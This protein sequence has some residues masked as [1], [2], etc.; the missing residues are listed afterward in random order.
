MQS[1][2]VV[3]ASC[4]ALL[5][6]CGAASGGR[7]PRDASI[8]HF[9]SFGPGVTGLTSRVKEERLTACLSGA[10]GDDEDA[11]QW[12]DNIRS[13]M[14]KWINPLR[15]LTAARL[16][17]QI[18][19][20]RD[21]RGCDVDVDV[22]PNTHSN[23]RIGQQPLIRMGS[24]GYM[25]SYNVLLHEFGHAFALNDTYQDGTT[26]GNCIAGQPQAVMCN[27]GFGD[28]Q[29]DDVR[30]VQ[31]VFRQAFPNDRPPEP[32]QPSYRLFAALGPGD[33]T[34]RAE[35]HLGLSG[36]AEIDGGAMAWCV[37]PAVDCRIDGAVWNEAR[38]EGRRGDAVLFR[39]GSEL[40]LAASP[41]ITIRYKTGRGET[42]RELEIVRGS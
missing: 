39:S 21:S 38:R 25:A 14:L 3:A 9:I 36:E 22:A 5:L 18:D 2:A 11:R 4:A 37:G 13:T 34:D 1:R 17:E 40:N 41:R 8:T 7:V 19:V 23:T 27:T 15:P 28:L 33:G 6:G 42:V 35:L 26:A 20:Y 30:G 32:G 29:S 12:T 16:V 24:Q 31:Q 10:I